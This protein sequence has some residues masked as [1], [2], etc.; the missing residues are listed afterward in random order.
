MVQNAIKFT[1]SGCFEIRLDFNQS[2]SCSNCSC[3]TLITVVKDTGQGMNEEE[4]KNLFQIFGSLKRVSESNVIKQHGIG[5][6]LS[7]CKE[8][9]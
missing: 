7:I 6:G 4:K 5:L 1:H 9:V 8:L 2:Q 3:G